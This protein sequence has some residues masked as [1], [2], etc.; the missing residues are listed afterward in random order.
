MG[1]W[2]PLGDPDIRQASRTYRII[3]PGSALRD[4]SHPTSV[5]RQP[6]FPNVF[7]TLL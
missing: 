7:L 3:D 6:L 1:E 2:S 4:A 5:L